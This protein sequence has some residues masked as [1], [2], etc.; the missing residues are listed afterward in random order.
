MNVIC[1]ICASNIPSNLTNESKGIAYCNQ[2][3]DYYV[4]EDHLMREKT[5]LRHEKDFLYAPKR[6]NNQIQVKESLSATKVIVPSRGHNIVSIIS[7]TIFIGILTYAV[8][9][10]LT[11]EQVHNLEFYLGSAALIALDLLFMRMLFLKNHDTIMTFTKD[12]MNI[13]RKRY[14]F[15]PYSRTRQ[16]K[17]LGDIDTYYAEGTDDSSGETGVELIFKNEKTINVAQGLNPQ[18]Q[19]WL[20]GQLIQIRDKMML[21]EKVR[22][23]VDSKLSEARLKPFVI[24]TALPEKASL[25]SHT[26]TYIVSPHF[27]TLNAYGTLFMYLFASCCFGILAIG[28]WGYIPIFDYEPAMGYTFTAFSL[29]VFLAGLNYA[30]SFIYRAKQKLTVSS[31]EIRLEFEPFGKKISKSRKTD[32]FIEMSTNRNWKYLA[33]KFENEKE[34]RIGFAWT[35]EERQQL[36]GQITKMINDVQGK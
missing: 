36:I 7:L 32:N 26:N 18:D 15:K 9:G 12:K 29:V 16:I 13:T 34:L 30:F 10:Y 17:N 35:R 1:P 5:V 2:C 31:S 21:D 3:T 25:K 22:E 8:Y 33:L 23:D 14:F 20:A 27:D 24:E 19:N 4:L 11:K 6:D 28:H